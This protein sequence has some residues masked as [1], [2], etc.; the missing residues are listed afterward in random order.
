M[1]VVFGGNCQLGRELAR[2]P[3][4]QSIQWRRWHTPRSILQKVPPSPQSQSGC[5]RFAPRLASQELGGQEQV[6]GT[7]HFTAEGVTTWH[8]FASRIVAVQAPL[9]GRKPRVTPI[10]TAD[11]PVA[12]RRSA[13][14]QL[15]CRSFAKVF[16]FPGRHWTEAVDMTTKALITSLQ[17]AA[18]VS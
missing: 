4:L 17:Q 14:S 12:A 11:H 2:R 3:T 9:S 13:N 15:D 18:H 1:I 7:Y 8:D 10:T 5:V 16:G 6:S